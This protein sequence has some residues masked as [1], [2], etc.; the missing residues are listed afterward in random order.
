MFSM[1]KLFSALALLVV[2]SAFLGCGDDSPSKPSMTLTIDG[3]EQ[4]VSTPAGIMQFETQYD[5][6]GR[7]LLI[8]AN[9]GGSQITLTVSNWDWQNPPTDAVLAK[10][11][12]VIFGEETLETSECLELEG[13]VFL[14]DGAL[15]TYSTETDTF[16]SAF[17]EEYDG[18][19]RVKSCS[20]KKISG[21]FD[22]Q[23]EGGNQDII[24]M[25]GTFTNVPYT[26][27]K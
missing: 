19:I 7:G 22:V 10:D 16:F 12:S 23:A 21:E 3:V 2:L 17:I 9:V 1:K 15:I 18:F 27:I 14:C 26:V 24:T 5:H 8:A 20:G 6:E 11:Y 25:K 4:K 13:S